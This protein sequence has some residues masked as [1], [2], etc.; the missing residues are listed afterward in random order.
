MNKH[1]DIHYSDSTEEQLA[2]ILSKA[3]IEFVHESENKG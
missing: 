3:G 2:V 1:K